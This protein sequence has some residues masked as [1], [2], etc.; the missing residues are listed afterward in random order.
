M[1]RKKLRNPPVPPDDPLAEAIATPDEPFNVDTLL[2]LD[3][4]KVTR[5][6]LA[7]LRNAR[8]QQ[9]NTSPPR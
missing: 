8:L 1:G 6:Q 5:Q 7:E 3:G 4:R 9:L 2:V